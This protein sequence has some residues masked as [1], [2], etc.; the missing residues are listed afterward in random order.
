M[1]Y[2][3]AA[4]WVVAGCTGLAMLP[5]T[6]GAQTRGVAAIR[7]VVELFTSQGCSSCPAADQLLG[8]LSATDPTVVAISLPIDY[9]DYLGWK[10]TLASPKNSALQKAYAKSRGDREVYTPQAVVNGSVHVLGSDRAAIEDAIKRALG[11]KPMGDVLPLPMSLPVKVSLSISG[12]QLNIGLPDAN[13]VRASGEVW[14]CG[15]AKA[16]SVRVERGENKGR[17]ITYH[18]VARLWTKVGEWTGQERTFTVPLAELKSSGI[19]AVAVIVP[20]EPQDART[21]EIIPEIP[22]PGRLLGAAET[23]IR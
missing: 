10:D 1:R 21:A 19:D 23:L 11:T 14:L 20:E 8:E 12:G 3:R 9:W 18:N 7:G 13:G 4:A 5:L 22:I 6:G 2:G 17:T 15:M 16:T